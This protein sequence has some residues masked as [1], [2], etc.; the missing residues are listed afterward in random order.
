MTKEEELKMESWE[1]PMFSLTYVMIA[2]F[3]LFLF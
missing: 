3:C 1:K 2:P